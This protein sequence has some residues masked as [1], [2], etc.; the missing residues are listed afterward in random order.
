M[1]APMPSPSPLARVAGSALALMAG[2]AL[3]LA[4]HAYVGPGAG[5]SLLTALWGVVAAVAVALGFVL[6]WP[7]RRLLRRRSSARR[8]EGGEMAP[9]AAEPSA[10]EPSVSVAGMARVEAERELSAAQLEALSGEV[11]PA[12]RPVPPTGQRVLD[13]RR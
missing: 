3:P 5:L 12:A 2:A 13:S 7:I 9:Q 6:M 8:A 4:A 10:A 1:K 11:P